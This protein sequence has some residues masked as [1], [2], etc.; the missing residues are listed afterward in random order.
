[1]RLFFCSVVLSLMLSTGSA[2]AADDEAPL[3]ISKAFLLVAGGITVTPLAM[4]ARLKAFE[5]SA[6][7]V[8]AGEVSWEADGLWLV[9]GFGGLFHGLGAMF[10][11]TLYGDGEGF[12]LGGAIT[13][14]GATEAMGL[15]ASILG[16]AEMGKD[17]PRRSAVVVRPFVSAQGA[18]VT[19]TF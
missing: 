9:P 13:A 15:A 10:A 6:D 1:M 3:R 12:L 14:L 11:A 16:L 5:S 7:R 2:R 19:G 8:T 4:V 17:E 18:G